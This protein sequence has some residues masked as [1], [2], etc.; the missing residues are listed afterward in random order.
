MW[1]RVTHES[2]TLSDRTHPLLTYAR[3]PLPGAAGKTSLPAAPPPLN[4]MQSGDVPVTFRVALPHADPGWTSCRLCFLKRLFSGFSVTV[5]FHTKAPCTGY[6]ANTA[7]SPLCTLQEQQRNLRYGHKDAKSYE[8]GHQIRDHADAQLFDGH[9]AD[10][11]AHEQ[12]DAHRRR[13]E[14]HGG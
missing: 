14:A 12:I 11:A 1:L 13:H 6:A 8:H 3:T 7:S 9:F 2:R 5:P 10:T 4:G